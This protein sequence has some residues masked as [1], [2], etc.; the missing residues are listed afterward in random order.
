MRSRA[1]DFGT[2]PV[3]RGVWI[4]MFALSWLSSAQLA[5]VGVIS[6]RLHWAAKY[7]Q[8]AGVTSWE[9]DHRSDRRHGEFPTRQRLSS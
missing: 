5:V 9:R 4:L 2:V 6:N 1:R 3:R 7:Y 8:L